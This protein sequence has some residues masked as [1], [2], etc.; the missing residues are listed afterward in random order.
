MK[1]IDIELQGVL[2]FG[3]EALHRRVNLVLPRLG[4]CWTWELSSRKRK[5]EFSTKP[6]RSTP[7]L[8][9]LNT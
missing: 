8:A 5:N 3:V 6:G 4:C 2:E 7:K 1:A 9:A